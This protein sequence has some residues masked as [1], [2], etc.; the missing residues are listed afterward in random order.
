MS[1]IYGLACGIIAGFATYIFRKWMGY[2][3]P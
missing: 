2:D 1:I 3:K